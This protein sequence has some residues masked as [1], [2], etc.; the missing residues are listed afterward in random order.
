[1]NVLIAEYDPSRHEVAPRELTVSEMMCING[2]TW[3]NQDRKKKRVWTKE[4]CLNKLVQ[5]VERG[6]CAVTGIAGSFAANSGFL[7]LVID[8]IY[9]DDPYDI[10]TTQIILQR[11]NDMKE[12]DKRFKKRENNPEGLSSIAVMREHV[13]RLCNHQLELRDFF[14]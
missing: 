10:D 7:R 8:R 1:M 13:H 6:V 11:L 2:I 14:D 3:G 12:S 4:E 9:D 5:S